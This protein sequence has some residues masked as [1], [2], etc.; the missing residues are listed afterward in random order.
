MGSEAKDSKRFAVLVCEDA[1]KW[2][3]KDV[4]GER[5]KNLLKHK[6][7]DDAE[8]RWFNACTGDLPA[9]QDLDKFQGFVIS[10]SHYSA[11]DDKEWVRKTENLIAS[12]AKKPTSS[13]RVVGICF[14]HQLIAKALGG[15][16]GP[17]P[18]GN[19]VLRSEKVKATTE[20]SL[21]SKLF[22]NGPLNMLES[23]SECV[24]EL[25]PK[26]QSLA[27]SNSCE[28]EIILF[29]E[30]ILGVQCHPEVTGEELEQKVLPSLM[31]SKLLTE[32]EGA[33]VQ[34]SLKFPVHSSEVNHMLSD[35][36]HQ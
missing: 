12:L 3:G 2:G 34:E 8:W 24:T 23:H 18:S 11:N 27:S 10:G 1:E 31:N 30:N 5:F 25:P 32:E 19:F 26:A 35:F 17:N 33:M 28:H 14:G 13:P 21:V 20:N 6:D 16:V 29:T 36:L 15:V 9:E 4:I 22:K 7:D